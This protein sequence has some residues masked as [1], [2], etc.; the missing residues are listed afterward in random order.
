MADFLSG[1]VRKTPPNKVPEDRYKFLKLQDAEPDLGVPAADG[2]VLVSD[3]DGKRSWEDSKSLVAGNNTE[4]IFNNEGIADG[5]ENIVYDK[6]TGFLGIGKN[7]LT[8]LDVDGFIT[9]TG[10]IGSLDGN[11]STASKLL[12]TT[13]IS[14]Q[15][16]VTGTVNFDGSSNVNIT[17][18]LENNVVVLGVNTTG[19]YVQG[20]TAGT[21]IMVSGVAN[22]GWTPT[23][24]LSH[25]GLENLTDPNADR[26]LFWDD[27]ANRTEWLSIGSGLIITGT[28]LSIETDNNTTYTIS[29]E[30]VTGGA[31]IRLSGSD[32]TTDDVTILGAGITTITRTDSNT[33]TVTTTEID[34]LESVTDRGASTTNAVTISNSTSSTNTTSGAL[35]VTGGVGVGGN[36]NA[37]GDIAVNGGD[38]TT[39]AITATIFNTNATTINIAGAGTNIN[40][41]SST[42]NTT[43][44]NNLVVSGDLTVNGSTT[45]IDTTTLRVEDKN[46]EIGFVEI[47]SDATANG[48]GITLLGV[49]NKTFNWFSVTGAWTSSENID[50]VS[51]KTY[52]INGADVITSTSLGQGIITSSLTSVGILTSGTWNATTIS[53]TYGGTGQTSYTDGQLLIGNSDGNTLTKS[54]LTAG[55]NV[56]IINGNGSITI[57]SSDTTYSVSTEPGTNIYEEI[58]RLTAGGSGSGSDDVILAVGPTGATYGLTIE[59]SGDKI[60]FSHAD[61]S[62]LSGQQGAAGIASIT[63]DEMGHV[64]AV[65]TATYLTAESDTLQQVTDRGSSTTNAVNI[66]N[67]SESTSSATG[68]MVVSGGI[69][70]NKNVFV[71][72]NVIDATSTGVAIAYNTAIQTTVTSTSPT[73][74][75]SFPIASFRSGKYLIQI[76]Q[77]TNYQVSEFRVIHNGTTTFVTEYSVLETNIPLGDMS[78]SI[79]GP[80]V[81]ISVVMNSNTSATINIQRTL[82]VV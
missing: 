13:S 56:S 33:I 10:F 67:T 79:I 73:I 2:Y 51:G 82:M 29:A 34:T 4:L 60:T 66:S 47:P 24:S 3:A 54:T 35:I 81:V 39:T 36:I 18:T 8:E 57:A 45:T 17:T 69:A 43:I 25:L 14:L 41:G 46:I 11:A 32:S 40:I 15:G 16:A 62:T 28:T 20:I 74:I 65:G 61:T 58:I 80:D 9:A 53:V 37:G 12:N 49:T 7:P 77:G 71:S 63:V 68:A 44:N 59:E 31:S 48:G 19:N 55:T 42:G 26:I 1:K 38:I 64:T 22:E 27:S 72:G 6:N 75:D 52:K 76:S 78:A 30:T 70:V 50:L 23:I 5:T 21:G